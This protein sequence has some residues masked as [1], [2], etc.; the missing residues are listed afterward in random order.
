MNLNPIPTLK[1]LLAKVRQLVRHDAA[2]VAPPPA[3]PGPDASAP[4]AAG[5]FLSGR[6]VH[7]AGTRDF[8]LYLPPTDATRMT[9]PRAL[10]VMLHGCSQTPEDFA[11]GTRMNEAAR[12]GGFLVLYPAQGALANLQRCW[13][14]FKPGHAPREPGEAALLADLTREV[15]ATH[16]VDPAR[17]YVA[18]L[19]AGGAMAAVLGA[20]YPALFAAVGIH[21]GV[22]TGLAQDLVSALRV[23]KSG[24]RTV[25]PHGTP[26]PPTIVFHGDHDTVVHPTNADAAMRPFLSL[27]LRDTTDGVTAQ[28]V[29]WTCHRVRDTSG[30]VLAEQWIVHGAGHAWSGGDAAGTFT[31]PG[32]PDATAAMVAFFK[33]QRLTASR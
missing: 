30:R 1:R 28:G 11:T 26:P 7:R 33:A 17:V 23:M 13:N 20:A 3:S 24:P 22:P 4:L 18:G 16:G 10:V 25:V 21:S 32:G 6:Y 31:L 9:A 2:A 15:M 12:A 14:W 27:G 5:Q 8:R 19:S 29:A